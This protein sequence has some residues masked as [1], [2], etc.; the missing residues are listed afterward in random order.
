[1]Y[2]F[3]AFF[4][5]KSRR[6]AEYSNMIFRQPRGFERSHGVR[7]HK[8]PELLICL[9]HSLRSIFQI[10]VTPSCNA[11][12]TVQTEESNTI[13]ASYTILSKHLFP[14]RGRILSEVYLPHPGPAQFRRYWSCLLDCSIT[15]RAFG[16]SLSTT[17]E[18]L[19]HFAN[20]QTS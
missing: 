16:K 14:R 15:S 9:L 4:Y 2:L 13:A 8:H 5:L 12:P 10:R 6:E 18:S 19:R 20:V 3:V 11:M 1:M 17:Q 7:E